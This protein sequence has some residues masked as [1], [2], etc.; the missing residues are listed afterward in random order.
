VQRRARALLRRGGGNRPC[1][2]PIA[3][4]AQDLEPVLENLCAVLELE[5]CFRDPGVAEFGLHNALLP[6]GT[7]FLEVVSPT[8]AG[9]T[10]GRLPSAAAATAATWRSQSDDPGRP[11]A[12]GRARRAAWS[13]R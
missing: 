6:I 3:L 5:V 4:V 9:T 1:D 12:H 13:G 2:L 8:R 10:A 7:S 11:Q